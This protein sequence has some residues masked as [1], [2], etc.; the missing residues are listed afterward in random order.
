MISYDKFKK[1]IL[2]C[3]EVTFPKKTVQIGQV[4]D[5]I[6]KIQKEF[7]K[8]HFEISSTNTLWKVKH[9]GRYWIDD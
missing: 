1:G 3:H 6:L 7:P 4:E 5:Y 2:G 8:D 9:Y